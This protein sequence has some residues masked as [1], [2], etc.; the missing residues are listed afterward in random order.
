MTYEEKRRGAT[1]RMGARRG[2]VWRGTMR[3]ERTVGG[4]GFAFHVSIRGEMRSATRV[5]LLPQ[6]WRKDGTC[7]SGGVLDAIVCDLALGE[8]G[9][10]DTLV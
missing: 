3:E 9:E 5:D 4:R 8:T 2:R 10:Y 6:V 1:K 7:E